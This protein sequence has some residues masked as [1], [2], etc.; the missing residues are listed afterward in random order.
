[1]KSEEEKNIKK[2]QIS[3]P[4]YG[5]F[6]VFFS[7]LSF[8]L[9]KKKKYI[10]I[11]YELWYISGYFPS[12][13]ISHLLRFSLHLRFY[14]LRPFTNRLTHLQSGHSSYPQSGDNT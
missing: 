8:F 4:K 3:F 2:K 7:S 1:M 10:Y 12:L 5:I 13:S 6:H 14:N 11:L 9:K